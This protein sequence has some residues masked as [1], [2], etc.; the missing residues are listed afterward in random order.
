MFAIAKGYIADTLRTVA[1]VVLQK[2]GEKEMEHEW[3]DQSS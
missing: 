2:R 1:G 3:P